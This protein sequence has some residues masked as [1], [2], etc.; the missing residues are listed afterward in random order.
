MTLRAKQFRLMGKLT[1]LLF[2][3]SGALF[4]HKIFADEGMSL[5][6]GDALAPVVNRL[7]DDI[8]QR[9]GIA[10]QALELIAPSIFSTNPAEG[11]GESLIQ[12]PVDL[13]QAEQRLWGATAIGGDVSL[14]L[15]YAD[16]KGQF[17]AIREAAPRRFQVARKGV[18]GNAVAAYRSGNALVVEPYLFAP[19]FDPRKQPWYQ[20]P[21]S[22]D[23]TL[24]IPPFESSL[25][26]GLHRQAVVKPVHHTDGSLQGVVGASIDL[27]QIAR[28]LGDALPFS[29]GAAFLMDADG[30]MI[31]MAST[32]KAADARS[33][34]T[35]PKM[36]VSPEPFVFEQDGKNYWGMVRP[37]T[38]AAGL[39]WQLLVTVPE[40]TLVLH[41]IERS[42]MNFGVVFAAL[43]LF[44]LL[45]SMLLK[46]HLHKAR[47]LNEIVA[48]AAAGEAIEPAP[49]GR[50]DDLG[51]IAAQVKAMNQRLRTDT[52]TGVLNR[53]TFIAQVNRYVI[54]HPSDE[55]LPFT[56]L[57]VDLN[58]FKAINDRFGHKA[59]DDVLR[60]AAQRIRQQSRREDVVARF[61][62]DE[63]MLA[64]F[65]V[66]EPSD[67]HAAC[68]KL[69]AVL[70][71]PIPVGEAHWITTRAAIGAAVYPS[72]GQNLNTLMLIADE[73]MYADKRSMK[74][75]GILSDVF[76]ESG[77]ESRR[78][79]DADFSA[80]D[81]GV[82]RRLP[83]KFASR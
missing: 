22:R 75:A 37:V 16:T 52:M 1:G 49:P 26:G 56:L 12:F 13:K 47:Q 42:L 36:P 78:E 82:P 21:V 55:G 54:S 62:G 74:E 14:M 32:S 79:T 20:L 70:A 31:T 43:I 38:H 15:I 48:R 46:R 6:A 28:R 77:S 23:R 41:F 7:D 69:R 80:R 29:D 17:V 57:F 11:S 45:V 71:E 72:D 4:A 5:L 35:S 76:P 65:G 9:V 61:G 68:E 67:I 34:I 25:G 39:Q 83:S 8:T 19:G 24:W 60:L 64:L 40:S 10:A 53:E 66:S 18:D 2:L 51:E 3:I 44:S 81:A 27:D 33:S 58:G 50:H 73:R 59:G 63:F 30:R